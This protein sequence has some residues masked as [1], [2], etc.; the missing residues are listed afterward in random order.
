MVSVAQAR[1][2]VNELKT[3]ID[4]LKMNYHT[5]REMEMLLNRT[6]TMLERTTGSKELKQSINAIQRTITILRTLQIAIHTFKAATGPLG[7]L[8][9][10]SG[11]AMTGVTLGSSLYD[12]VGA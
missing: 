7:I 10:L 2:T 3:E 8:L 12:T 6:L 9:A 4:T 5:I 11:F 1:Q